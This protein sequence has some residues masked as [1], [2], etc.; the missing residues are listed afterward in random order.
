[1][2]FLAAVQYRGSAAAWCDV[3]TFPEQIKGL[4]NCSLFKERYIVSI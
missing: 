1:M 3:H 2:I 4:Y